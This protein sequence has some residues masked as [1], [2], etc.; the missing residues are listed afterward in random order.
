[1]QVYK[2]MSRYGAKGSLGRL[3]R[4]EVNV[5]TQQ[6]LGDVSSRLYN[7]E[8]RRCGERRAAIAKA[9]KTSA[10]SESFSFTVG[11]SRTYI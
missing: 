3:P 9:N 2:H 1:M 6:V 11:V 5:E 4:I 10:K 8:Y 7:I